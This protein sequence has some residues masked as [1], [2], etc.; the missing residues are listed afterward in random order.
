MQAVITSYNFLGQLR[1]NSKDLT[2]RVVIMDE[3]HYIKNKKVRP[4][5]LATHACCALPPDISQDQCRLSMR[6]TSALHVLRIYPCFRCS[7]CTITM[8]ASRASRVL[9]DE[10]NEDS[11]PCAGW[12]VAGGQALGAARR[13]HHP[14]DGDARHVA[15][16]GALHSSAHSESLA[17]QPLIL[18][19]RPGL[20]NL[21]SELPAESVSRGVRREHIVRAVLMRADRVPAPQGEGDLHQVWRALLPER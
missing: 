7:A 6:K 21:R 12:E 9:C 8:P 3:A 18:S 15:S 13:A 20:L 2:F 19:L 17:A 5:D 16:K 10:G 11:L 14:A 1:D 4:P